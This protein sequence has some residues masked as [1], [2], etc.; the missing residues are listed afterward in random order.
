MQWVFLITPIDHLY[1]VKKSKIMLQTPVKNKD[2]DNTLTIC[3]TFKFVGF[4]VVIVDLS[5]FLMH[6]MVFCNGKK[7]AKMLRN[8]YRVERS[9]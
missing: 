3:P 1:N 4:F 8:A 7:H 6:N 2:K 9:M 5:F